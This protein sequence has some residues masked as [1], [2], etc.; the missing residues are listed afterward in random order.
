M[1]RRLTIENYALIHFSSLEFEPGFTVITGETGAGKSILLGAL[2]LL[3][4]NRADLQVLFDKNK[5]CIVEAVFDINHKEISDLLEEYD[6]DKLEDNSLL[7]RR[8]ISSSGKSRSFVND[9]PCGLPLLKALSEYLI[10]IHS[11]HK[12][13]DLM[14]PSFLLEMVDSYI[15]QEE[16]VESLYIPLFIKYKDVSNKLKLLKEKRAEW[17]K[18]QDYW[19]FIYRELDVLQLKAGE[20]E[21]MENVLDQQEHIQ[22]IKEVVEFAASQWGE[23]ENSV[24]LS[25][26]TVYQKLKKVAQYHSK[27]EKSL[28]RWESVLIELK[29]LHSEIDEIGESLDFSKEKKESYEQRLDAIYRLENKHKVKTIEELIKLRNSLKDKLVDVDNLDEEEKDMVIEV[30]KIEAELVSMSDLWSKARKQAGNSLI[31][32]T[33]ESLESLGMKDAELDIRWEKENS[34]TSSGTDKA[35]MLFNA[36]KGGV[37]AELGKVVSGGELSRLMLALKSVVHERKLIDCLILDEIDTGV[38][39]E[40]AGKVASMMKKMSN[41]MQIISITHLPQIAAKADSHLRV[42]K[43]VENEQ[44]MSHIEK[45]EKDEHITTIAAMMSNDNVTTQALEAAKVLINDVLR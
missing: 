39:G 4:G 38:S 13:L 21:E 7:L 24:G 28:P 9:T 41:Y 23:G 30:T 2:G 33:K 10:D 32:K 15:P 20:Q 19:S 43:K 40:I 25:L 8:E 12:T 44:T 34:Y 35:C 45:L 14:R 17:G 16:R 6:F 5:K 26:N 3:L 37:L 1:L 42:F 36:N 22:Q 18:E 11:Q 27:I 31:E 29:D